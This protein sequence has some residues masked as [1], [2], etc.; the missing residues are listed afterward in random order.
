MVSGNEFLVLPYEMSINLYG[1][2]SQEYP[3]ILEKSIEALPNIF[4][5]TNP[6]CTSGM[7]R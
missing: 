3:A 7:P 5:F 1:C 4:S 6:S 2:E